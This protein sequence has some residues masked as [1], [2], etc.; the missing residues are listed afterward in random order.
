M[1]AW[2]RVRSGGQN[3][4][5]LYVWL[6][7]ITGVRCRDL[8]AVTALACGICGGSVHAPRGH[9]SRNGS[10]S[11]LDWQ[12][13]GLVVAV[14][15][16]GGAAALLAP[17]WLLCWNVP[18]TGAPTQVPVAWEC[19]QAKVGHPCRGLRCPSR[20]VF[21]AECEARVSDRPR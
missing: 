8:G 3:A 10:I 14:L 9:A 19:E 2:R 20:G 4:V 1:L 16:C 12:S 17:R 5:A 6:V 18:D 13:W 21:A 15:D 11:S 7:A